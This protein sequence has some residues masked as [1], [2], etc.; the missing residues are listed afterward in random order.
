MNNNKFF[1][2]IV[3][4][5]LEETQVQ[6]IDFLG[7]NLPTSELK[8]TVKTGSGSVAVTFNYHGK[9]IAIESIG[10]VKASYLLKLSSIVM[11]VEDLARAA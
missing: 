8:I 1:K 5:I 6:A 9:C 7:D 4:S 3:S 11:Q 10:E 2:L